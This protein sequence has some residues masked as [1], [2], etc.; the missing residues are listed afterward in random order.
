MNNINDLKIKINGIEYSG[1][2]NI[3]IKRSMLNLCG[4]IAFSIPDIFTESSSSWDFHLGDEYKIELNGTLISTGY[5]EEIIKKYGNNYQLEIYGRDKVCD[6]VDCMWI[7][8]PNEWFNLSIKNII[9]TFCAKYN[10]SVIVDDSATSLVMQKIEH[11]KANEGEYIIDLINRICFENNIFP[12]S[13]GDGKLT[14]MSVRTNNFSDDTLE[15]KNNII[16]GMTIQNITNRYSSYVVKGMGV[17][18]N[19]KNL[20]DYIQCKGVSD[21]GVIE[22]YRTFEILQDNLTDS[23]KCT[24]RAKF[25]KNLKAGFSDI[26]KYTLS[27]WV[28]SSGKVW[29]LNSLVSVKDDI[30]KINGYK[31]IAELE[32]T[33]DSKG[34]KT[35]MTL[36]NKNTFTTNGEQIKSDY[37]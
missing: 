22:R 15:Y 14:L 32:H 10:L 17:S 5:I 7:D 23:G 36:V 35:E 16:A 1:A 37:V 4:S 33:F 24:N 12:I 27:D 30:L 26:V 11:F 13:L 34:F 2:K 9:Q 3:I 20:S 19:K 21:D 8:T 28:Q 31:L 29:E 25:E 6:L 18:S